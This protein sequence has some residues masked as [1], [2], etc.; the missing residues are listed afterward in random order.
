MQK[1]LY[2]EQLIPPSLRERY[3]IVDQKTPLAVTDPDPPK[4]PESVWE[5]PANG[6][7]I[8]EFL[9]DFEPTLQKL[10]L[11]IKTNGEAKKENMMTVVKLAAALKKQVIWIKS[12]R[13]EEENEADTEEP[14]A[15]AQQLP[16]TK[17]KGKAANKKA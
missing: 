5:L 11:T 10:S 9:K 3:K 16:Q 6:K 13:K 2:L 4:I 14:K 8:K 7:Y 17:S 15:Q 1:P 12:K